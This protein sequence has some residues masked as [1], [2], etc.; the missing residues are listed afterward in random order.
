MKG[1]LLCRF[2]SGR[3][4]WMS[5]ICVYEKIKIGVMN[6]LFVEIMGLNAEN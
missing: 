6:W 5:E 3:L 1:E 4:I 2:E